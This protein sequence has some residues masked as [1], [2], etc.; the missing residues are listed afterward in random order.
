[1]KKSKRILSMVMAFLLACLPVAYAEEAGDIE[2]EDNSILVYADAGKGG[3]YKYNEETNSYDF[4]P[5]SEYDYLPLESE[6]GSGEGEVDTSE[7]GIVPMIGG[8][9]LSLVSSPSGYQ[10]STCLIG[11]GFGKSQNSQSEHVSHGTGFLINNQYLLTAAHVVYDKVKGYGWSNHVAV[12]VGAS[13][14]TYKQYRLGHAILVGGDFVDNS[15]STKRMFD[16]WAIVKLDSPVT[17][18][19]SYLTPRAVNS[20]NDMSGTYTTQGYPC[21]KNGC[22]TNRW[23]NGKMYQSF[24]EVKKDYARPFYLPV[25][26][27]T[28]TMEEG[29]S[30]S[31]IYKNGFV[32]AIGVANNMNLNG[33]YRSYLILINNWLYNCI[34]EN[35]Y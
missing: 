32:E 1:M 14:G 28:L 31:P 9:G 23:N 7:R 34:S 20:K 26:E 29:Q 16:D 25:V 12:Y 35:C 19:V 2:N 6:I 33:I 15:D 13:G 22:P 30:G 27:G 5:A 3:C 10:A 4:I 18:S 8:T 17:V 21:E 11:A 24:G